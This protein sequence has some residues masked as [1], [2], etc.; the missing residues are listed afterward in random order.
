M[1]LIKEG[2]EELRQ[3]AARDVANEAHRRNE[4]IAH[5]VSRFRFDFCRD[6]Y[7]AERVKSFDPT[8]ETGLRSTG[9]MIENPEKRFPKIEFV[10]GYGGY[11]ET[12]TFRV[13]D[14]EDEFVFRVT[15]DY[16]GGG[17]LAYWDDGWWP[18]WELRVP[19]RFRRARWVKVYGPAQ[20]AL[21]LGRTA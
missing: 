1:S 18:E 16:K 4:A 3:R 6:R 21:A 2:A 9:R 13:L 5:C 19:Q 8:N 12:T 10:A 20:V 14:G 17:D 15:W 7:I 11:R